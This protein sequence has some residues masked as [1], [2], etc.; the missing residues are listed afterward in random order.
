MGTQVRLPITVSVGTISVIGRLDLVSCEALRVET[1][2]VYQD[3][4]IIDSV[5]YGQGLLSTTRW[6]EVQEEEKVYCF[7]GE[8]F[9]WLSPH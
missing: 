4:A 6:C 9:R 5:H 7:E 8:D 3:A 2:L 1:V